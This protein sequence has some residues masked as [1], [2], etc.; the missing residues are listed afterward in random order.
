MIALPR[1]MG[2][3]GAAGVAPE[4]T[5]ASIRA[6]ADAGCRWVEFDAMLTGDGRPVL[7]HD[8]TL[9]RVTGAAGRMDGTRLAELDA[10]D[11]GAAFGA[12]FAGERIPPLEAALRCCLDLDLAPNVEI[13]P[14]AGRDL[15]TA[16]AVAET[17][18]R[19]WPSERP[20]M[21]SSFKTDCLAVARDRAPALPRGLI[22]LELGGD[23]RDLL[24]DL[25]CLSLHLHD[26]RWTAD[27]VTE[28]RAAGYRTAVF[29]VNDPERAGTLWG[30]GLDCVITDRPDLL[31][32]ATRGVPDG[33]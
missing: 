26:P 24:R 30:W 28:V 7:F 19:R 11:A 16:A 14:S 10:L 33:Y 6:A 9:D 22:A 31:F 32:A 25:D 2:H 1:I 29:T 12:A 15:E 23:W 3:R 5:L 8:D 21:I 27:L 4:N 18:A 13:K 17:L 20:A